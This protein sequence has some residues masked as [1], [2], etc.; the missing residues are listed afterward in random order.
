MTTSTSTST[1]TTIIQP[2]DLQ[3]RD[4]LNNL[5]DDSFYSLLFDFN[6][7]LTVTVV[8]SVL[9]QHFRLC[10]RSK[11]NKSSSSRV[12]DRLKAFMIHMLNRDVL[13]RAATITN[14]LCHIEFFRYDPAI[15]IG[16]L[17]YYFHNLL[18]RNGLLASDLR[19][20]NVAPRSIH[21]SQCD[22]D[23]LRNLHVKFDTQGR[24]D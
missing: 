23:K 10:I 6:A 14:L 9:A 24:E 7:K 17:D 20:L 18:T 22:H 21:L 19:T 12:T 15:P 16:F 2:T 3:V 1:S 5:S 13:V 11:T 4:W 8:N